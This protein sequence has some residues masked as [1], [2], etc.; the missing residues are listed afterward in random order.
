MHSAFGAAVAGHSPLGTGAV[1]LPK[2]PA[3]TG[4]GTGRPEA[5]IEQYKQTWQPQGGALP[6]EVQRWEDLKAYIQQYC[7]AEQ[8]RLR[9]QRQQDCRQLA[10]QLRTARRLQH[11][12]PIPATTAG[13]LAAKRALQLHEQAQ[14]ASRARFQE[15][16]TEVANPA[17]P[18]NTVSLSAP[19]GTQQAATI[20]ACY[21]YAATGGLFTVHPTTAADQQ[22]LLAAVDSQLSPEEQRKCLGAL[23][24]G[25]IQEDEAEAALRSLPRGKAPSSDGLTYEFYAALWSEIVAKVQVL[26]LG[27]V[28]PSVIDPTQ[29]AFVPGRQIAD[30]VLCH[31]EGVDYLQQEQQPGVILFLDFAKAYDMLNRTWIQLCMQRMGF[32]A[33]SVR[34][35]QLLLQGTQ[36]QLMCRQLQLAAGF[37]AILLPEG[38][39]AP[40]SHQHADDTILHA[41]DIASV[42]VLLQQAVEPFCRATG[43]KLNNN[44]S[45]VGGCHE[46]TTPWV[47]HLSRKAASSMLGSL[48]LNQEKGRPVFHLMSLHTR[49]HSRAAWCLTAATKR[50]TTD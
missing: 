40:C 41:A 23:T 49:C 43:G 17:Q 10:Q 25:S 39:P 37:N 35:V 50:P 45:K 33:G 4:D 24:D 47:H 18:G 14:A 27:S 26:R 2:R 12:L 22:L 6:I 34:W 15:L 11:M 48:P 44:K 38:R 31:L 9:Q 16:I 21:Y 7:V 19:G 32:P 28:L 46:A 3:G 29:T 30:N 20:F 1:D 5:A 8:K 36:A 42:R 13:L